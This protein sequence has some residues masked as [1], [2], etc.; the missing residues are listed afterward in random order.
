MFLKEHIRNLYS[1][2]AQVIETFVGEYYLLGQ[3]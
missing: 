2:K 3:H 1:N